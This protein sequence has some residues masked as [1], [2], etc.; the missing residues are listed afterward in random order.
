MKRI[1]IFEATFRKLFNESQ[2]YA[3]KY[4][5]GENIWGF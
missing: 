5:D 4:G 2:L 3:K 1:I